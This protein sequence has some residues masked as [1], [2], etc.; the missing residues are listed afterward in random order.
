MN[1]HT[2]LDIARG[3]R[4]ALLYAPKTGLIDIAL[5]VKTYIKVSFG[6]GSLAY[7]HIKGISFK[8]MG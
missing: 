6:T 3:K 7:G 2:V 5:D 1:T 8:R 4:N